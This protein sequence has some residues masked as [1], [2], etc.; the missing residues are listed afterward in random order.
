MMLCALQSFSQLR[1][2]DDGDWDWA[3][4][5]TSSRSRRDKDIMLSG[6]KFR[7]SLAGSY[8]H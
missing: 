3:H 6:I 8:T 1:S 4:R 7:H 2:R 5:G